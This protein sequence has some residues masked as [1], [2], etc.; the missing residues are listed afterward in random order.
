MLA[1]RRSSLF[2]LF[3]ESMA[4][5][6]DACGARLN[7]RVTTGNWPWWLMVSGPDDSAICEKI[8]SGTC[9]PPTNA[10]EEPMGAL[11][12]ALAGVDPEPLAIVVA[13]VAALF[14]GPLERAVAETP[15]LTTPA[16]PDVV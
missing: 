16:L 3:T 9:S 13:A 10:E 12:V 11:N 2:A 5:P 6:S 7:E 8:W 14:T 15:V 4:A 1:G